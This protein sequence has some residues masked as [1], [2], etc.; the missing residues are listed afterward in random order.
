MA[1]P[2]TQA[3][4]PGIPRLFGKT[5]VKLETKLMTPDMSDLVADG[6]RDYRLDGT[7]IKENPPR[8]GETRVDWLAR[9]Q[10]EEQDKLLGGKPAGSGA[11][12]EDSEPTVPA[13]MLPSTRKVGESEEQYFDRMFKPEMKTIKDGYEV[14]RI[15]CKCF[16]QPT[17][18]FQ[19]FKSVN[20]PETR[21][22]IYDALNLLELID[23]AAAFQPKEILSPT[24]AT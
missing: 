24:S 7:K 6:I 16:N 8:E 10:Q 1:I 18:S 15:L 5:L 2:Q 19:E 12:G 21:C 4:L 17:P 3:L 20:W 22:F 9:L 23:E 11:D 13:A 14:L